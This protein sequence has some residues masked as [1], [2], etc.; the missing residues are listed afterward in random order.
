MELALAAQATVLN[1]VMPIP[2]QLAHLAPTSAIQSVC[3]PVQL[4]PT[5]RMVSANLV[6]QLVLNV[7]TA[8]PHL[9]INVPLA[10]LSFRTLHVSPTVDKDT[11]TP[12]KSA[13]HA[14][15]PAHNAQMPIL[16]LCAPLE[17][18]F[19]DHLANLPAT[20]DTITTME[21]APNADLDA[22]SAQL[23]KE[24]L[25]AV[26]AAQDILLTRLLEPAYQDVLL[27]NT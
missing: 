13:L 18:S 12:T 26:P 7:L 16:A 5:I 9:A 4:E 15:L 11:I 2:A 17:T 10:S 21:S 22:L 20:S 19:K 3:L 1:A 23:P 25:P 14:T 6:T 27:A 8:L 24:T